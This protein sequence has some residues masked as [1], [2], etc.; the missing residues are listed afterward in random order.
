MKEK[1]F[2]KKQTKKSPSKTD[3]SGLAK[4]ERIARARKAGQA[5]LS[6]YG[7]EFYVELARKRHGHTTKP[8]E[9]E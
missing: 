7:R 5:C 4:A 6:L 1:P 2:Q 8:Q 9:P 3:K